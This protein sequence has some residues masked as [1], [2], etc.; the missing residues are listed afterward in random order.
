V[1]A[2]L[3]ARIKKIEACGIR[4]PRRYRLIN[5]LLAFMTERSLRF[6]DITLEYGLQLLMRFADKLGDQVWALYERV[7]IAAVDCQNEPAQ[8]LCMNALSKKFPNSQRVAKLLVLMTESGGG[9]K[10]AVDTYDKL[11]AEDGTNT[12]AWKR[13]IASLRSEGNVSAAIKCLNKYLETFSADH[14]AWEQ[15][16]DLYMSQERFELAK[17]CIE[18]LILLF[19]EN[20]VYH[21][22]YAETL[23][24]LGG[25]SN[26]ELA[27][28]YYAQALEL[29]PNN[30]VRALY[31][32][33]LCV[34]GKSDA[35]SQD[36]LRWAQKRLFETYPTG[37]QSKSSSSS[38]EDHK[39][40]SL[41]AIV[42]SVCK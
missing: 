8:T 36:L 13:K 33:I 24:T 18:E 26:L 3:N 41:N 12:A 22:L 30:N 37:K 21:T 34:Q 28:M 6:S 39:D 42:A 7:Y 38:S 17:F 23:H 35:T 15:L 5:E 19:P 1:E 32:L 14:Y 25:K 20:H 40:V 2:A 31:G 11:I 29:K 4:S 16:L 27:R 9:L 10:Q